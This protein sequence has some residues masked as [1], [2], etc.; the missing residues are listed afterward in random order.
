MT[1]RHE[2]L[3]GRIGAEHDNPRAAALYRRLGYVAY[4]TELDSWSEGEGRTYVTVNTML[5][6][7]LV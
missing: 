4:G 6:R 3:R 5:R 1:A 7:T 2:P